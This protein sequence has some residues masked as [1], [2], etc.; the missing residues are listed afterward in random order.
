MGRRGTK[1]RGATSEPTTSLAS[2]RRELVALRPRSGAIASTLATGA[3]L[4]TTAA[5]LAPAGGAAAATVIV[6]AFGAKVKGRTLGE[7][8]S[9]KRN[10]SE[11]PEQAALFDRNGVG[12]VFDGRTLSA[13]VEITPRPWQLTTIT[14]AGAS[15]SPQI[16]AEQLRRQLVQYDITC[17][18]LTAICVGYKFAARD[19]AAG[20]LDTLIGPVSAPL[21]GTTAVV[22][23]V[24]VEADALSPAYRRAPRSR[25]TGELSLPDGLCRT[26]TVAATRVCHALAQSGFGSH[27]MTAPRLREFHD[28]VLAQV[29]GPLSQPGWDKCG[30]STGFHTRT[31]TPSRGHWNGES[32]GAWN[33]LQSHRQFTTLTLTPQ[34]GGQALAQPL[35]SYL[36]GGADSLANAA[37]YGLAPAVGQ[38]AAGLNQALPVASRLPLRTQGVLID[39]TRRLG[40]GIPAGGA[41]MFVGSRSDKTR[42]FVAVSPAD[43]PL[44]ISGPNL[45]ALQMV[46]RL[47]TQDLRIAVMIDDDDTWR[48]LVEHRA[49]PTLTAGTLGITPTDVVVTTPAWWERN[50]DRCMGAA[51]ILV[52]EDDPGQLAANSLVVVTGADGTSRIIVRVD[53]QTTEVG[54]ELTSLERRLLLGGIDTEGAYPKESEVLQLSEMAQLPTPPRP[55]RQRRVHAPTPS[56]PTVAQVS[57]EELES[58]VIEPVTAAP[59][60]FDPIAEPIPAGDLSLEFAAPADPEALAVEAAAAESRKVV[61]ASVWTEPV[62]VVPD[63]PLLEFSQPADPEAIRCAAAEAAAAAA[64]V[65]IYAADSE[66]PAAPPALE[67]SPPVEDSRVAGRHRR[68]EES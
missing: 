5:G 44:W 28:S 16:S 46:G 6:G 49:T 39:E 30:P 40:F 37:G 29:A 32:A 4:G 55:R 35:V 19:N 56:V 54:W 13:V 51:V 47:S 38:Q 22:V 8:I 58:L 48:R 23:S 66:E 20:V 10:V 63:S 31:Y 64:P 36:V 3:V 26:I 11:L 57:R 43:E 68:G 33:Y 9:L 25:K 17:S 2:P 52:T 62:V 41:G 42:V 18:R 27:L 59:V 21:G 45:F 53:D 12:I 24:D 60:R 1:N 14:A 65:V 67:F 61:A 7:W 50:R 15:E 34:G